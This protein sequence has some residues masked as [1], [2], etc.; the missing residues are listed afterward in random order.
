M[1]GAGVGHP[2]TQS[3]EGPAAPGGAAPRPGPDWAGLPEDLLVEVA[4]KLVAQTEAGWA[5][6]CKEGSPDWWTEERLQEQM[7][8]RERDGNCCLFVFARV[9]KHWRKAQLKVGG[10][11]RTR[12]DS[13]VLLPG[14]VAMVKWALAEGCPRERNMWYT[15]AHAAAEYGQVELVEWLCGEGGFAMDESVMNS[16]AHGGNLELVRWLRGEGCSWS[17]W[18]CQCAAEAGRLG[19]LEWLRANGC[20]WDFETCHSAVEHGHVEVLR[21]ARENGCPWDAE[22]RDRAAAKL[23][24]TDDL[25]NLDEG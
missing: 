19:I 6:W 11:L 12:V 15:M 8:K 5:A 13:D 4:G 21:W 20:P 1:A 10:P 24:Y 2:G 3:P 9:C 14:S 7:A 16:A 23:G 18:T 17:T 22:C 25:G